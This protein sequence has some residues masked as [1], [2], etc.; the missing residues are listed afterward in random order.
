MRLVRSLVMPWAAL[1]SFL[2][3]PP[4][5]V[6]RHAR[7]SRPA[8]TRPAVPR[9]AAPR[10]AVPGV[11]S[12]RRPGWARPLARTVAVP[13]DRVRFAEV[14]RAHR[15]LWALSYDPAQGASFQA[16]HRVI[17]TL[18]VAA[19]DLEALDFALAEFVAPSHARG[20]LARHRDRG[21]VRRASAVV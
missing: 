3:P 8:A 14:A 16:R 2:A 17:G 15:A 19:S 5:R 10:T 11:P 6:A 4:R 1:P 12:P 18:V 9:T 13:P 20:Y 7:T 21:V